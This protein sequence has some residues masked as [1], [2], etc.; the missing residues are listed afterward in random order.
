MVQWLRLCPS[1]AGDTGLSPSRRTKI[2]HAVC[3]S[4]KK[5]K[6]QQGKLSVMLYCA[7]KC[8]FQNFAMSK[9]A[10]C[11]QDGKQRLVRP[12]CESLYLVI[13]PWFW[14]GHKGI[15][16]TE[17]LPWSLGQRWER[18]VKGCICAETWA[19]ERSQSCINLSGKWDG[20]EGYALH[21]TE[22]DDVPGAMGTVSADELKS[23]D[24]TSHFTLRDIRRHQEQLSPMVCPPSKITL[25]PD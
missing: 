14:H 13:P 16:W 25:W 23:Q 9:L 2:P 7:T 18:V 15:R 5:K 10:R 4:Q 24:K 1:N 21:G 17:G 12:S 22:N 3:H 8:L 20:K 11:S 19:S 6:Q